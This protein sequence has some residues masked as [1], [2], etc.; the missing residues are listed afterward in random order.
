MLTLASAALFLLLSVAIFTA[1]PD[2]S[3]PGNAFHSRKTSDTRLP[4]SY[5][6]TMPHLLILDDL[7]TEQLMA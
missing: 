7:Y 1:D 5:H 3:K 4:L 6:L 2:G